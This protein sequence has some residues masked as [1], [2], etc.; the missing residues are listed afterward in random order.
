MAK[1]EV[2]LDSA[3]A[4]TMS[5]DGNDFQVAAK[6]DPVGAGV[7]LPPAERQG[8][9]NTAPGADIDG[10]AT[11]RLPTPAGGGYTM[12]GS[13][14][15]IA[16]INSSSANNEMMARLL[17]VGPDGTETLV[18]RASYRPAIG[19]SRQLFQLHP[20]GWHFKPGHTPK[21]ELLPKETGGAA[22]N[23]YGRPANGQGPITVSNLD[24]RIPT[25]DKPGA[26]NGQ[27]KSARPKVVPSGY[28]LARDFA[29]LPTGVN[30]RLA[31]GKVKLKGGNAFVRVDSPAAWDACHATVR[32]LAPKGAIAS[33]GKVR[34][35]VIA[36][37][38][39]PAAIAGGKRGVVKLKLTK[40][41]RKALRGKKGLKVQ[42]QLSTAEQDGTL[43]ANR[44]ASIKKGKKKKKK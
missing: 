23:S 30:A 38:K 21:L 6:F 18:D 37:N 41:A 10:V 28:T 33:G 43:V 19:S 35:V 20:S 26:A 44:K 7:G 9:C 16:D 32:L 29:A 17:D 25:L 24:F 31:P 14:T 3:A 2:R 34:R 12:M 40:K 42:V 13:P 4:K 27:V 11:Y 39:V 5:A 8:A 15:V 1:G 22:F 36:K